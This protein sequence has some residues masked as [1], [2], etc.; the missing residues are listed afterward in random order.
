MG[1]EW[2]LL[3]L[4]VGVALWL[5]VDACRESKRLHARLAQVPMDRPL[6]VGA[7]LF[8]AQSDWEYWPSPADEAAV[9]PR[10]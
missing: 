9:G 7:D 1:L 3:G 4:L 5:G 10:I 6:L 2:A 8:G